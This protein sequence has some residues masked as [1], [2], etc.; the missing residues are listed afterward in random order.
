MSGTGFPPSAESRIAFIPHVGARAHEIGRT[1]SGRSASGTRKPQ[2]S[3]TGYSNM[4]PSAHA[5]R[6]L[7]NATAM[8]KPSVPIEITVAGMEK[9]NATGCSIELDTEEQP[10][11]QERRHHAVDAYRCHRNASAGGRRRTAWG[12]RR[13]SS[14]VPCHR[15]AA[16]PLPSSCSWPTRCPSPRHRARRRAASPSNRRP[17]TE[18]GDRREEQW[19]EHLQQPVEG[20]AGDI[21]RW[22]RHDRQHAQRPHV[23]PRYE[24]DVRVLERRLARRRGPRWRR[25]AG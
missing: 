24:C 15:V 5:A 14:S 2:T 3:Q 17:G 19:V 16:W 22:N 11:P 10:A 4:F 9:A 6:C 21:F 8:K 25:R 18:E 13:G 20:V 1:Q 12:R 7:T 23:S